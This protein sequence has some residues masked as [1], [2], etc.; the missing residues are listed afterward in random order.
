LNAKNNGFSEFFA[1]FVPI[2]GNPASGFIGFIHAPVEVAERK[3]CTLSGAQILD[4]TFSFP[5]IQSR[6]QAGRI[7]F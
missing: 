5:V 4:K 3:K 1:F 6:G 7:I 2:P